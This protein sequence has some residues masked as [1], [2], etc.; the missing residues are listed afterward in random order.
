MTI[1][2]AGTI[3]IQDIVNEFGGNVPHSLTEYYRGAG[4]VPDIPQ[5]NKIPTSGDISITD[6]YGSVNEMVITIT[7]GA[8]KDSFGVGVDLGRVAHALSKRISRQWQWVRT[9]ICDV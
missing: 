2:A 8:L 3:S 9:Y 7:T 4:R 5:N 1:K 6:F